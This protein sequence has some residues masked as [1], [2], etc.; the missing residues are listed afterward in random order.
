MI[1]LLLSGQENKDIALWLCQV[2]LQ[3]GDQRS[4]VQVVFFWL[5][6]VE[7]LHWECSFPIALLATVMC[8]VTRILR[9]AG[10]VLRGGGARVVGW[11]QEGEVDGG[12]EHADEVVGEVGAFGLELGV[13][14]GD[15]GSLAAEV[16]D[17]LGQH[18]VID[19]DLHLQLPAHLGE[20]R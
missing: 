15:G 1:N 13:E 4:I 20:E 19:A 8:A 14:V 18:L 9:A 11:R 7:Y 5:C 10:V 6:G 16:G 2:D 3:H 12:E 17:E